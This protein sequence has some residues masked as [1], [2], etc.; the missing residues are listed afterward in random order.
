MPYEK[1]QSVHF[2]GCQGNIP[3]GAL[4]DTLLSDTQIGWER[5]VFIRYLSYSYRFTPFRKLTVYLLGPIVTAGKASN[6]YRSTWWNKRLSAAG[7]CI[8]EWI[9]H[10]WSLSFGNYAVSLDTHSSCNFRKWP[11]TGNRSFRKKEI[12][13]KQYWWS[14]RNKAY[15]GMIDGKWLCLNMI[16]DAIFLFIIWSEELLKRKA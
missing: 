11:Y 10:C 13:I 8:F 1:E 4:Y 7:R 6:Y 14:F 9:H 15:P 2:R 5:E 16:R 12:R 3:A